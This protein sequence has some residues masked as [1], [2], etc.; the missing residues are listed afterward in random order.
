MVP[1]FRQADQAAAVGS[2][3]GG[4]PAADFNSAD[5]QAMGDTVLVV[6]QAAVT[7]RCYVK[8][9]AYTDLMVRAVGVRCITN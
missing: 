7:Y 6:L 8:G 3:D 5:V 2:G 4:G 1:L 9:H